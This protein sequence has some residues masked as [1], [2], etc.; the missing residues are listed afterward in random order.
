MNTKPEAVY[1]ELTGQYRD[2]LDAIRKKINRTSALRVSIFLAGVLSIYLT[3]Q[4]SALAVVMATGIFII[5]FAWIVIRHS[6]QHRQQQKTERLLL[7]NERELRALQQGDYS[8]YAAGA[9]FAA[10]GHPFA[11]DLDV[12]GP[13]SIFQYINRCGTLTGQERLAGWFL[14]PATSPAKILSRQAA[15]KDLQPD[16]GWRQDFQAAGMRVEEKSSDKDEILE[17]INLPADFQTAGFRMLLWINPLLSVFV[18][19]LLIFGVIDIK[20]FLLYMAFDLGVA[21]LFSKKITVNHI[22]VSKKNELI[23]KYGGLMR[24]IE[25]RN[26]QSQTLQDL[27]KDLLKTHHASR[28][29]RELSKIIEAFDSRLNIFAWLLLNYFLQ[30][31]IM[32]ARRLER[33]RIRYRGHVPEWFVIISRFDAFNSLATFAFNRPDHHYPQPVEQQFTLEAKACGHPLIDRTKRIDNDVSFGGWKQFIIVTGANM[34]GKSTYLRTVA[35]NFLLAMTGAPVCA[36]SFVFSPAGMFTSLR[37]RDNLLE[38]ESYF[39]AELKR[40]KAIIDALENDQHLFVI[41][42]EILKGTNSKDKQ[43]GSRALLK[44]LIRYTSSGLIATHDLSLGDLREEYPDNIRNKRFEV[45][46]ENN[47]LIFDYKLKDGISQNLNATFLMKKMGIT[48]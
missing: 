36:G 14:D 23:R 39:F 17:W 22:L 2:R 27:Q 9:D 21:F 7:I 26:F 24:L 46:I 19:M 34:A 48:I 33:W 42:D 4:L 15:V 45:E 11:D 47:E 10:A 3:A 6:R 31:D 38:S 29:M 13:G 35:V 25:K 12:F 41:L 5:T 16:I 28:A 18:L 43:S 44:Q 1:T 40:L 8:Q 37:T 20:L 32:Q 30:W